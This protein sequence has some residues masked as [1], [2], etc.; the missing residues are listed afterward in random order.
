METIYNLDFTNKGEAV[1]INVNNKKDKLKANLIMRFD[2]VWSGKKSD[3]IYFENYFDGCNCF[4]QSGYSINF[5][6]LSDCGE[7]L[8]NFDNK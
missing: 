7:L 4:V 2:T 8:S 5:Y 1:F 3:Y 6:Q